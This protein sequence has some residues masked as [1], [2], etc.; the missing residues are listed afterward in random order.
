VFVIQHVCIILIH[1][2]MAMILDESFIYLLAY[3]ST[4]WPTYSFTYLFTNIV[5]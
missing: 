4:Y 1:V 2:V 5:S 3:L